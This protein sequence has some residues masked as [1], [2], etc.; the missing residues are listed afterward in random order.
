MSKAFCADAIDCKCDDYLRCVHCKVVG[1]GMHGRVVTNCLQFFGG[2]GSCVNMKICRLYADARVQ[3][4]YGARL[5]SC[6][7]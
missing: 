1:H 3:R 5:K 2:Y 4:I 6:A 7:N